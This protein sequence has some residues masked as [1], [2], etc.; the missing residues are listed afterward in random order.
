[1][2]KNDKYEIALDKVENLGY[3]IEIEVK[4]IELDIEEERK[5]IDDEAKKLN[6][7]LDDVDQRGYPFY[8][9]RNQD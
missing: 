1:M 4:K 8:F 7:N 3:F 5:R 2:Y 9:I 6:L